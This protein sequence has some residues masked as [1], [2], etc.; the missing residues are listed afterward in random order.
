MTPQ[1]EDAVRRAVRRRF[2]AVKGYD[3]GRCHPVKR[4]ETVNMTLDVI[5]ELEEMKER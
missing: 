1:E 4:E 3:Q 2:N 5:R